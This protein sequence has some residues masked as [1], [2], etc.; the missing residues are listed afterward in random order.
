MNAD[1]ILYYTDG[2]QVMVTN[3]F[4][5][6]K[7]TLYQLKGITRH[8]MYIIHP[9][10][11]IQLGLMLMGTLVFICGS[12]NLF[13]NQ[14]GNT[15]DLVW[16]RLETHLF[17]MSIGLLLFSAGMII[18]WILKDR[19]A[20]RIHTAEGEKDLVVSENKEYVSMIVEALNRAYLNLTH[21][22]ESKRAGKFIASPK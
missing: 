4:I 13:P 18:L 22:P 7:K 8:G 9:P 20:V 21:A 19:Y 5:K 14:F 15:V 10:K 6:V 12:M 2:H 3:S 17:L 1:E 16:F 11:L